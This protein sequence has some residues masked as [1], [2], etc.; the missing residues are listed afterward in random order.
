MFL[1]DILF[2]PHMKKNLISISKLTQNNSV[3]VEF[4]NLFYFVKEKTSNEVCLIGK[5][6]NGLYRLLEDHEASTLSRFGLKG[7]QRTHFG[8]TTAAV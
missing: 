7:A 1:K 4:H 3:V 2:V 8:D 5:L 6:D